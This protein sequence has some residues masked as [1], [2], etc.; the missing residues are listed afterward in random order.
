MDSFQ[1]KSTGIV[2]SL[3]FL[4]A[5][6]GLR[7]SVNLCALLFTIELKLASFQSEYWNCA[8]LS[9]LSTQFRFISMP[10]VKIMCLSV[11]HCIIWRSSGGNRTQPPVMVLCIHRR[12]VAKFPI[13]RLNRTDESSIPTCRKSY[14]E[15]KQPLRQHPPTPAAPSQSPTHIAFLVLIAVVR[16]HRSCSSPLLSSCSM[17][18]H[19][20][21]LPIQIHRCTS[22]CCHQRCH[23][24][25]PPLDPKA[26]IIRPYLHRRPFSSKLI[27]LLMF[28]DTIPWQGGLISSAA[29]V[30]PDEGGPQHEERNGQPLRR[31][32]C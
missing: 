6:F 18:V 14:T 24:C 4:S 19:I 16:H 32:A 31:C 9:F 17:P 1:S 29:S 26:T 13:P 23:S 5:C 28:I 12:L 7:L 11:H 27:F 15:S 20:A 8:F 21:G 25:S 30:L 2:L 22:Y 10:N 3:C